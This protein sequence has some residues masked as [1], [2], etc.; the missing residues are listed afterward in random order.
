M[1][2]T[3]PEDGPQN[4]TNISIVDSF[5][6]NSKPTVTATTRTLVEECYS[7]DDS[8]DEDSYTTEVEY[9]SFKIHRKE[10]RQD[11]QNKKAPPAGQVT[12]DDVAAKGIPDS[13]STN[14][15][16]DGKKKVKPQRPT[17]IKTDTNILS[18]VSTESLPNISVNQSFYHPAHAFPSWFQYIGHGGVA[19]LAQEGY[20]FFS[21]SSNAD[22]NNRTTYNVPRENFPFHNAGHPPQPMN[23][24]H[25]NMNSWGHNGGFNNTHTS[26]AGPSFPQGSGTYYVSHPGINNFATTTVFSQ[27]VGNVVNTSISNIGNINSTTYIGKSRSNS[28]LDSLI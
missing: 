18:G 23:Y 9:E 6:T 8:S 25:M 10:T 22:V 12:P 2:I 1:I 17:T 21:S 26:H 19:P 28:E 20:T 27:N 5:G 7:S 15:E 14:K 4:V 3:N 24:I 13:R 11:A 16:R